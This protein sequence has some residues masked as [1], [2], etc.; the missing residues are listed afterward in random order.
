[1][2]REIK[3]VSVDKPDWIHE[4]H[5]G[6]PVLFS[7]WDTFDGFARVDVLYRGIFVA[8]YE[9]PHLWAISGAIHVDPKRF[10]PKLN[11]EGFVGDKLKAALE[12]VLRACHPKVLVPFQFNP[13]RLTSQIQ[14][15]C[16]S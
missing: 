2:S 7:S 4:A 13:D 3:P 9:I 5:I 12:P 6:P 1:M 11:R 8:A 15:S 16:G 10:R 14:S